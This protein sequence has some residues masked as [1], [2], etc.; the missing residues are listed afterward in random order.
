MKDTAMRVTPQVRHV[1]GVRLQRTI[2][3][4]WVG[5]VHG[6]TVFFFKI[7]RAWKATA[8]GT[9]FYLAFGATLYDTVRNANL[10]LKPKPEAVE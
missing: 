10:K 6:L 8:Q 2:G 4:R 5:G 9:G 3:G 1:D 7:G